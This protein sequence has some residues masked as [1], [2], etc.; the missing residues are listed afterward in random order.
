MVESQADR[1]L[2]V[3]LLLK[4]SQRRGPWPERP[5]SVL[6]FRQATLDRTRFQEWHYTWGESASLGLSPFYWKCHLIFMNNCFQEIWWEKFQS[7][8]FCTFILRFSNLFFGAFHRQALFLVEKRMWRL[9]AINYKAAKFHP[10]P[11]VRHT[12]VWSQKGWFL[13]SDRLGEKFQMVFI[14][15]AA[16]GKLFSLFEIQFL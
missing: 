4:G 3:N 13:R 1:G 15:C 16:L 6:Q 7:S 8:N 11:K 9:W 2:P 5:L 10:R 12:P 14:I